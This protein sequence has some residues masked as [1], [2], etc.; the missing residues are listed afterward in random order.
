MQKKGTI[1]FYNNEKG[2]GFIFDEETKSDI[3]FHINDWKNGS[4]PNGNDDVE[5]ELSSS[6]N[7]KSKAINVTL[8]KSGLNFASS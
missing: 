2:F 6:Q 7:G 3:Y 4:V 1:K 8:I 5:F